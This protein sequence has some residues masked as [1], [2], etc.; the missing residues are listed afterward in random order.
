MPIHGRPFNPEN[1]ANVAEAEWLR[2]VDAAGRFLDEWA[3]LALD[4]GGMSPKCM[5]LAIISDPI[6]RKC[7]KEIRLGDIGLIS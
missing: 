7:D 3:S 2:A 1:R 5:T 4:F 6:L